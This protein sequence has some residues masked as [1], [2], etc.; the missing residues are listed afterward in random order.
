MINRKISLLLL[1][2]TALACGAARADTFRT[3]DPPQPVLT[4]SRVEV[5]EFFFYQCP[6]CAVADPTV[7][8][9][10]K[11]KGDAIVFRRIP[12]I[13]NTQETAGAQ[14]FYTFQALGKEEELHAKAFNA[15]RTLH[16][17]L[18]TPQE[19]EEWVVKQGVDDRTWKSAFQSASVVQKTQASN[20]IW[21]PYGAT[22]APSFV[23]DGKYL[24]DTQTGGQTVFT[25]PKTLD[26]L[27]TKARADRA[28]K[29]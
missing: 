10:V 13:W 18:Q 17:S 3:I 8:A 28:K 7:T 4:G 20:T 26:D 14:M 19:I 5:I 22:T 24:T 21:K 2:L 27:V 25:L 11:N 29:P 1:A 12:I 23:V 9:W 15:I 16:V 6:H